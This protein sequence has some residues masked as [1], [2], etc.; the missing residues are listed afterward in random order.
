MSVFDRFK[1]DDKSIWVEREDD[2]LWLV[3]CYL[4]QLASPTNERCILD[5]RVERNVEELLRSRSSEVLDRIQKHGARKVV[6]ELATEYS[7]SGVMQ[8]CN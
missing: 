6:E 1:K 7:Q 2:I 4:E 8:N 3:M 5:A